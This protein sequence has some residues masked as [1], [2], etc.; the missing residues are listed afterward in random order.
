MK[1]FD[2]EFDIENILSKDKTAYNQSV[3]FKDANSEGSFNI[4]KYNEDMDSNYARS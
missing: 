4:S 2:K 1:D 3:E